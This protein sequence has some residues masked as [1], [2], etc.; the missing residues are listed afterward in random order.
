[1]V[2]RFLLPVYLLTAA[3]VAGLA[4]ALV[5]PA[6]PALGMVQMHFT[7]SPVEENR[8]VRMYAPFRLLADCSTVK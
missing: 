7:V 1:M 2:K 3:V 8:T 4:G 6:A 5:T